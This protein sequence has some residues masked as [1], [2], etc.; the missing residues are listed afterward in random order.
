MAKYKVLRGFCLGNG[1][2]VYPGEVLNTS[3]L[4]NQYLLAQALHARKIEEITEGA[5]APPPAKGEETGDVPKGE[6][7]KAE[8]RDPEVQSRRK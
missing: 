7:T 8:S 2:D 5:S 6:T 1:R 4:P 3:D